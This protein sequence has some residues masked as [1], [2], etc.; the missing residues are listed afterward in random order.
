MPPSNATLHSQLPSNRKT[1]QHRADVTQAWTH[2]PATP[3]SNSIGLQSTLWRKTVWQQ[4]P[5]KMPAARKNEERR[6]RR[7]IMLRGN[8]LIPKRKIMRRNCARNM[9]Y[10]L[11]PRHMNRVNEGNLYEFTKKPV[12]I[13]TTYRTIN[14]CKSFS[15]QFSPEFFAPLLT[16]LV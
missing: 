8:S 5:A 4:A 7:A 16:F 6:E 13:T 12:A 14:Q 15:R 11:W 2:L 10:T 9:S 1:Q 3:S